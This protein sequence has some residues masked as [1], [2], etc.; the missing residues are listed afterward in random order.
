MDHPAELAE[1]DQTVA[2][3]VGVMVGGEGGGAG[4]GGVGIEAILAGGI[5]A[6]RTGADGDLAGVVPPVFAAAIAA[7]RLRVTDA[8]AALRTCVLDDGALAA[9]AAD[10]RLLLNVNTR[11][12]EAAAR[13]FAGEG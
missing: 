3:G 10:G 11:D 8:V 9:F 5:D 12:D 2:V 6:V 13:R 1:A 7:G 4:A